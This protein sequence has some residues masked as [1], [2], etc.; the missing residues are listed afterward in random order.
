MIAKQTILRDAIANT[1]LPGWCILALT[2]R[3]PVP[4]EGLETFV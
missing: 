1:S 2:G 3:V 4:L